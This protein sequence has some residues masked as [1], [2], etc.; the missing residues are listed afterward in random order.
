MNAAVTVAS[1]SSQMTWCWIGDREKP[2]KGR[3]KMKARLLG[4]LI[5]ASIA[6]PALADPPPWAPAHGKRAKEARETRDAD[7]YYRDGRSYQAR[8]LNQEERS[9]RGRE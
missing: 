1:A 5:A 4:A 9:S 7:R 3:L 2:R 6:A 8:R